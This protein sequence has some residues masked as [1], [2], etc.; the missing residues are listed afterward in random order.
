MGVS[1]LFQTIGALCMVQC[2]SRAKSTTSESD[3]FKFLCFFFRLWS[4]CGCQAE[5]LHLKVVEL[6]QIEAALQSAGSA[7][8]LQELSSFQSRT[9]NH[10]KSRGH[11]EDV[12]VACEEHPDFCTT[13]TIWFNLKCVTESHLHDFL[14]SQFFHGFLLWRW[15]PRLAWVLGFDWL[16]WLWLG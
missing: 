12:E 11:N 10:S 9:G 1:D 6:V 13:T 2:E 3:C 4:A 14:L 8:E 15:S 16:T 5:S 7:R